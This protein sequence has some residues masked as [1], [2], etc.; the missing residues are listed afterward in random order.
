MTAFEQTTLQDKIA[1]AFRMVGEDKDFHKRAGDS[2]L[3]I[4]FEISSPRVNGIVTIQGG[5]IYWSTSMPLSVDLKVQWQRSD[6]L[7]KWV[8]SFSPLWWHRILGRVKMEGQVT[9]VTQE[10]LYLFRNYLKMV[11]RIQ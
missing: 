5:N 1:A 9:P 11:L 10:C 6:D 7:I 3:R 8:K 4:G 2:E